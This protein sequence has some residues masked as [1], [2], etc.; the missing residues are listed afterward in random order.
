LIYA[1]LL[2]TAFSVDKIDIQFFGKTCL[3]ILNSDIQLDYFFSFC[4]IN[5]CLISS[6]LSIILLTKHS[7]LLFHSLENRK[8]FSYVINLFPL[9]ICFLILLNINGKINW[10]PPIFTQLGKTFLYN[11]GILIRNWLCFFTSMLILKISHFPK[12]I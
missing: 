3:A 11:L 9:Q 6:C 2:L 4:R 5:F 1:I 7:S 12:Y 8:L 10:P